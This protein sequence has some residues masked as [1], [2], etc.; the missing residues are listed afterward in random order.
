VEIAEQR[1]AAYTYGGPAPTGAAIH[2]TGG[3]M[4]GTAQLRRFFSAA[5]ALSV[6]AFVVVLA[7]PAR[8]AEAA[9]CLPLNI[10]GTVVNHLP[11]SYTV[12]VAEFG[13]GS[14]RCATW[15]AGTITCR[16]Y[17]LPSG[18]ST[19][20]IKGA[21]WDADGVMVERSYAWANYL[22]N[23][24]IVE[25]VV[26]GFTWSKITTVQSAECVTSSTYGAMCI[27]FG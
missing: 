23:V 20:D 16:T 22:A 4:S 9:G 24:P 5:I 13:V 18:K 3:Y 15:N 14:E 2:R 19:V 6:L 10:C 1:P 7:Q 17:W 26:P 27:Y 8:P 12:K 21:N 11:S 25:R